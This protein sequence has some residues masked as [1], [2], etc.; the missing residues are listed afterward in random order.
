MLEA[1]GMLILT[2]IGGVI[3]V[4]GVLSAL[5]NERAQRLQRIAEELRARAEA[6]QPVPEEIPVVASPVPHAAVHVPRDESLVR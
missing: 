6:D 5:G 4:F 1:A 3:C 2:I